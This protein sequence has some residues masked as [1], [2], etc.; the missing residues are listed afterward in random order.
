MRKPYK[1]PKLVK[2]EEIRDKYL[3]KLTADELWEILLAGSSIYQQ[4]NG[5]SYVEVA[6]GLGLTDLANEIR[7]T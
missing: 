4:G 1:H 7:K 5:L 2:F 3:G 6:E